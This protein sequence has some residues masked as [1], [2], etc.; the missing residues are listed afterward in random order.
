MKKV[1]LDV[2]TGIDDAVA[3]AMALF[4]KR[5][6]VEL[7]TCIMG[8]LAV[9]EIQKNTL[10]FLNAI[11]KQDILVAVGADKPLQREKDNSVQAHGKSG[12]GKYKFPP[13][14]LKACKEDAV[15]KM[16][17]LI[18]DSKTPIDI[19][20]MGPLTNIAL[21]LLKH[22]EVKEKIGLITISGGLLEDATYLGFNVAQDP[23]SA[24]IVF[25]SG[26]RM[27]VCPSDMGHKAYL[28]PEEVNRV[29][30]TN[31]TGEMLDI[32][33]KSYHDRH[34]KIGIATHDPCAVVSHIRPELF[35]LTPMRVRVKF[36][37]KT[38]TGIIHFDDKSDNP[39]MFVTT[40]VDVK[41][42]K[43]HFFNI[44]RKMP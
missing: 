42:F 19:I 22:P 27:V 18:M 5:V 17:Q 10:N 6:K 8:N 39:N 9:K 16:H 3:I 21:L 28:T 14:N 13:H 41:K 34:I 33:F 7:I 12:L 36:L 32:I 2:D 15:E 30:E 4:D 38:G 20:C 11:G 24:D 25:K 26:I 40:D 31:K 35:E 37:K 23:E 43:R 44:L 1:I 29:K